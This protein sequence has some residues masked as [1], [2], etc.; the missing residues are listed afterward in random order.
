MAML[1]SRAASSFHGNQ[2]T[3]QK[4]GMQELGRNA[5][6]NSRLPALRPQHGRDFPSCSA[7][8]LDPRRPL[9]EIQLSSYAPHLTR[10]VEVRRK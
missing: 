3:V 7:V 10:R 2:E 9:T 5:A 8:T 6:K 4:G 1:R